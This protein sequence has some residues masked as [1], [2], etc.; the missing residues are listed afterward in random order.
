MAARKCPTCS[1]WMR[2]QK[3]DDAE[4]TCLTCHFRE[5]KKQEALRAEAN[6]SAPKAPKLRIGKL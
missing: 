1:S 5:K 3:R 4:A 2:K 6:V